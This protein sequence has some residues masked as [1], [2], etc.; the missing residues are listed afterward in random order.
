MATRARVIAPFALAALSVV[1]GLSLGRVFDSAEFVLPVVGAAV[2]PHALGA[3][4]RRRGWSAW[5]WLALVAV[6]LALYVGWA[7]LGHTTW[8]GL[9]RGETFD[10]LSDRLREGWHVL[11]REPAP[12]PVAGGT[13][14]LAVLATWTVATVADWLAFHRHATL[15]ALSPRSSCSS[16]RPRS[17]PTST[18]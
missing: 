15:A 9:P 17:E 3:L 8:F 10:A 13:E 16:G 5:T 2:I 4:S 1:A 11:R 14:L 12:V 18:R 6:A 7:L